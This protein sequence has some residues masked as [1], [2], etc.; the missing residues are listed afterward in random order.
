MT[1]RTASTPTQRVA[2]RPLRGAPADNDPPI[3]VG[4]GLQGRVS[5]VLRNRGRLRLLI[6]HLAVTDATLTAVSR[7][8]LAKPAGVQEAYG[9]E[10]PVGLLVR[11]ATSTSTSAWA[12]PLSS[13]SSDRAGSTIFTPQDEKA[14]SAESGWWRG[15]GADRRWRRRRLADVSRAARA[16]TRS[17]V[18]R[19]RVPHVLRARAG[20]VCW[21]MVPNAHR[22]PLG[23]SGAAMTYGAGLIARSPAVL[24]SSRR[25]RAG[26]DLSGARRC[27]R[28]RARPC[29]AAGRW[30]GRRMPTRGRA[31]RR[32]SWVWRGS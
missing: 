21:G 17:S 11:A 4:A 9:V 20:T 7:A 5:V 24:P 2:G 15:G 30:R 13:S 14:A 23:C 31:R 19:R 26:N 18:R 28:C 8:P 10:F 16:M 1:S 27:R 3:H 32:P 25:A 29:R 12:S 6:I 22:A